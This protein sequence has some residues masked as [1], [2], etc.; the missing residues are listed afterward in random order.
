MS[1]EFPFEVKVNLHNY[2][3]HDIDI[4][5][6]SYILYIVY[7]TYLWKFQCVVDFINTSVIVDN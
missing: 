5:M 1:V 7:P 4:N 6:K 2:C 3:M